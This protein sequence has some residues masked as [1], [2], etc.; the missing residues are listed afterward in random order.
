MI[1]G[2]AIMTAVTIAASYIV[3]YAEGRIDEGRTNGTLD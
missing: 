1:A 2:I 3:G